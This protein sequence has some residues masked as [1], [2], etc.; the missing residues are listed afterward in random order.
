MITA[1]YTEIRSRKLPGQP[2]ETII[3]EV[4]SINGR[5]RKTV[6]VLRNGRTVS[7]VTETLTPTERSNIQVRRFTP[8]LY[9]SPERKTLTHLKKTQKRK[10][11]KTAKKAPHKTRRN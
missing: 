10:A 6:R 2:T 3:R 11:R 5:G 8:N 1:H 9:V 7:A 4:Q